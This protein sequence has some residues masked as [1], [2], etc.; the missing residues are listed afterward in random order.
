[1]HRISWDLHYAPVPGDSEGPPGGDDAVGAV[2][3]RTYPLI[4]APL[5]PPGRYTVRLTVDGKS[6]TQPLP[7]RLDPRVKTSA[8]GLAQLASLSKSMYEGALAAHSKFGQARAL[9]ARLDQA[10]GEGIAAFKAAVD[11][12]APLPVRRQPGFPGFGPPAPPGPPTLTSAGAA[13]LAAAMA[14]Q[15]ADVTPTARQIAACDKARQDY[16]VA[17]A[18][19]TTLETT[20]LAGLNAKRRAAGLTEVTGN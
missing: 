5:A 9:I 16:R 8:A 13:M 6:M 2:P 17:L 18:R 15:G 11:S 7:L 1:M 19:W 20:G 3:H 14:M 12:I 10:Q 4:N